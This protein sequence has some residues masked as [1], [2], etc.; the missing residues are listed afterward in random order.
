MLTYIPDAD[1]PL[2]LSRAAIKKSNMKIV[3]K[4]IKWKYL[5]K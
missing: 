5:V 3:L 4:M 2:L 1:I